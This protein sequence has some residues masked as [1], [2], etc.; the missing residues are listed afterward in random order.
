MNRMHEIDQTRRP[1]GIAG[2]LAIALLALVFTGSPGAWAGS[3]IPSAK[4]ALEGVDW[5]LSQYQN[6]GGLR[7]ALKTRGESVVRFEGGRFHG[8]VGCNQLMGVYRLNG[9]ELKF[10]P[11]IASTMMA[12]PQPLLQQEQAVVDGLARTAAFNITGEQLRLE[13]AT[14]ATL[15]VFAQRE[16]PPLTGTRSRVPVERNGQRALAPAGQGKL[17]L[18]QRPGDAGPA[19]KADVA[20]TV[21]RPRECVRGDRLAL[22]GADGKA[23]DGLRAGP[24]VVLG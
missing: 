9:S 21:G 6:E 1:A 5:V 19:G 7:D 2:C 22:P 18:S 11:R 8:S 24:P 4:V 3:A 13:D 15:L 10:D 20:A 23:P 16:T 14:G 17:W 12:C